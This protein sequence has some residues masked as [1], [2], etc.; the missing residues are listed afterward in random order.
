[1][2]F[3]QKLPYRKWVKVTQKW[4]GRKWVKMDFAGEVRTFFGVVV[5]VWLSGGEEYS[6][7]LVVDADGVVAEEVHS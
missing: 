5:R 4:Y 7:G 6:A 3:T 2:H 1:M